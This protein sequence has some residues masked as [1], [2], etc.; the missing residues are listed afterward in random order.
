MMPQEEKD[1]RKEERREARRQAEREREIAEEKNQKPVKK[2]TITIEWVRSRTWGMNPKASAEVE[3]H[4]GS[5]GRSEG[6]RCSGCGYD[7]ASTVVAEIFNKFLKYKLYGPV[8]E[9][10]YH[11]NGEVQTRPYGVSGPQAERK[12]YAGGIGISCYPA[13]AAY[14]GGTFERVADGKTFDVFVYRDGGASCG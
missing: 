2:M 10:R 5:F 13:I 1:R 14:I 11:L 12:G 3:F 4:D 7:K 6:H 8:H 9:T